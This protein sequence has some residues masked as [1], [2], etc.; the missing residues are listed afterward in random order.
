MGSNFLMKERFLKESLVTWE[1]FREMLF[2][3]PELDVLNS[4][5]G[6]AS[7]ILLDFWTSRT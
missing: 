2:W 5:F 3:I 1:Q 4:A 7:S 6:L